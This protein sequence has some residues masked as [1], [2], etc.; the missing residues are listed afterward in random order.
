M[1]DA[2]PLGVAKHVDQVQIGRDKRF[3][4]AVGR[5]GFDG[6]TPV[7]ETLASAPGKLILL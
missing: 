5:Q 6:A 2:W 1:A 3:E 4:R 7:A